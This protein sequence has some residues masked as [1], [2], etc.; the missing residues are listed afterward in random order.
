MTKPTIIEPIANPAVV[1]NFNGLER[2]GSYGSIK[3]DFE[4]NGVKSFAL[5]TSHV[6][7]AVPDLERTLT[8]FHTV[9]IAV[10][11]I[12]GSGIF[13]S[14][15]VIL[16]GVGSMGL[17]LIIWTL[18]GLLSLCGA[19]CFGELGAICP[20]AGGEYQYIKMTYGRMASFANLWVLLIVNSMAVAVISLTFSTYFLSLFMDPGYAHF[21]FIKKVVSALAILTVVSICMYGTKAGVWVQNG[22]T[23]TKFVALIFL[24]F[25]A[26]AYLCQGHTENITAGF[27]GSNLNVSEWSGALL[28]SLWAYNGWNHIS[29]VASEVKNPE[30]NVPRALV[31]SMVLVTITYIIINLA[32]HTLLSP[33][34]LIRSESIAVYA[35]E[36]FFAE[37]SEGWLTFA[38]YF[39][40]ASVAIS[41][42]GAL[43]SITLSSS[44]LPYAGAVEGMMPTLFGLV[45]KR[46]KTPVTSLAFLVSFIGSCSFVCVWPS[47]IGDLIQYVGFM[48]WTFWGLC[49]VAVIVL[50]YKLPDIPRPFKIPLIIP[51]VASL[52]SLYLVVG[53]LYANPPPQIPLIIPVVAS[54]TS[55]YLVVGS[56]YANP[57]PQIPLIIPVVAS[58]TSLYLVVGPLYANPP[59]QIPLIIPVVASLTSLYLVVGSLYANPPP[60]IPLIIPVVASLT[61]LYLVVGSLYANPLPS[62]IWIVACLVAVP[63]YYGYVD[64]EKMCHLWMDKLTNKLLHYLDAGDVKQ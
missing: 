43:L 55:L 30:K 45:S 22:F 2:Q 51:V 24:V 17:S 57:P 35:G 29:I 20:K 42:F 26:I 40:G 62:L 46:S 6:E 4:G 64:N 23:I 15:N 32:Y 50:R 25:L 21:E 52:T 13:I 33:A 27:K 60:Q 38:R 53:S 1:A 59:P 10:G 54:L 63:V 12:I 28:T 31:T 56:L 11:Q 36:K 41:T 3:T 19:L 14:P 47:N 61:S 34:D 16:K 58:L 5:E 49:F 8:L 37:Y 44:R 7:I 39:F 18:G 9:S 48:S